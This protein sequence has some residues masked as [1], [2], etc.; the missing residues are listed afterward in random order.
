MWGLGRSSHPCPIVPGPR[1]LQPPSLTV[2]YPH[3]SRPRSPEASQ[4]PSLTAPVLTDAL[5]ASQSFVFLTAP[6]PTVPGP[7]PHSNPHAPCHSPHPSQSWVPTDPVLTAPSSLTV[8]VPT[9]SGPH[10]PEASDSPFPTAPVPLPPK[11]LVPRHTR[12]PPTVPSQ[13]SHGKLTT[14][15]IPAQAG[16]NLLHFRPPPL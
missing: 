10:S 8:S 6:I 3:S 4:P 9:A 12:S 1:L 16:A 2:P 13:R 14:P 5:P 11:P 7:D 15:G